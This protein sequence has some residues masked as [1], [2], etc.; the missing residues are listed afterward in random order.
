MFMHIYKLN[1]FNMPK[2]ID[3]NESTNTFT[4]QRIPEMNISDMYGESSKKISKKIFNEI[5]DIV[6]NL[7]DN[8]VIYPDITGYNFIEWDNKIWIFDFGDAY[9][10]EG[11]IDSLFVN[12]FILGHN[13][14]NP[15]FR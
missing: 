10:K 1:K 3:Y 7:Y 14:W 12:K 6:K 15:D 11:N 8:G 2:P 9:F 13:G 5:R 4:M